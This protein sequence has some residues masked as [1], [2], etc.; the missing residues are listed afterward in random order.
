MLYEF[1]SRA[2]GS[3]V[4][5][6]KVAERLLAVIGKLPGETG[7]ITVAQMPQAIAA[8]QAAVA[9][10]R[11]TPG[12]DEQTEQA[13]EQAREQGRPIPVSLEQ[14]AWPLI[15]MLKAALAGDK[16]ITWGV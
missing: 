5:T 15:D 7:I 12:R 6:Q 4:M 16:D 14:R 8:L 9:A 13:E 11:A 3:V 2:T 10:E 1:K